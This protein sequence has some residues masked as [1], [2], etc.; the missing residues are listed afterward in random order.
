MESS[1]NTYRILVF[2]EIIDNT[3]A[4]NSHELLG[5]A[6]RMKKC[7]KKSVEVI[8]AFI[9]N[10]VHAFA[11]MAIKY[12]ADT[13]VIFN[14]TN[15]EHYRSDC[16]GDALAKIVKKLQPEIVLIGATFFGSEIAP[17]VAAKLQTGLAAHCTELK[18]D[19]NERF[20]QVVPA[21]G[22]KV[23]GEIITP[24][25]RPQMASVKPGIMTSLYDE[26]RTGQIAYFSEELSDF[27]DRIKFA[28]IT[29]VKASGKPLH[30]ADCI[31]GGGYGIGSRE[32]W[33][34]LTKIAALLNGAT[35]CTRPALDEGWTTGE[36]T[37]IGTSGVAVRP[38]VYINAG[39]SGAAHHTCGIKEAGLVISINKDENAPIFNSSDIKIVADWKK[40]LPVLL[41]K[42][43]Q[44]NDA[45]SLK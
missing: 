28:G 1:D 22:G 16:Y 5:E 34:V 32:N 3:I 4:R 18:I 29:P 2:A 42:L 21:F 12:G 17:T 8:A 7:I 15:L 44:L 37:M 40:V 26:K 39:I 36:Q 14:N 38:K 25:H 31:I 24:V 9:G 35:G 23:L 13:C 30:E 27:G 19:N 43:N 10:D 41:E 33:E 20:I 45:G 6:N 11:D